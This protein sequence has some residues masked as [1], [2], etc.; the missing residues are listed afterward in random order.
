MRTS[1]IRKPKADEAENGVP[2]HENQKKGNYEK[3]SIFEK[4]VSKIFDLMGFDIKLN[5]TSETAVNEIDIL[6]TRK[7]PFGNEEEHYI[8]ECKNLNKKVGKKI[9]NEVKGVL[10][11]MKDTRKNV[12]DAIIVSKQGFSKDAIEAAKE[13]KDLVIH[14]YTY[15][16]LLAEVLDFNQYLNSLDRQYISDAKKIKYIEQDF[17]HGSRKEIIDGFKFVMKWL[18]TTGTKQ[19]LLLGDSGSGK[20]TFVKWLAYRMGK[21]YKENPEKAVLPYLIYLDNCGQIVDLSRLLSDNLKNNN[22][23]P[24]NT[25]QFMKLLSSGKILFIL[26][27]I[28]IIIKRFDIQTLLDFLRQLNLFMKGDAKIILTARKHAFKNNVEVEKIFGMPISNC[29][30]EESDNLYQKDNLDESECEIVQLKEF[31]L[32][33]IEAYF[34]KKFHG[35]GNKFY[36]TFQNRYD[37]IA[38]S[39]RPMFLEMIVNELF[40]SDQN[41]K[42]KTDRE[43]YRKLLYLLERKSRWDILYGDIG[44]LMEDLAYSLW[45]NDLQSIDYSALS[46]LIANYM[47]S[48]KIAN[49]DDLNTIDFEVR[50]TAFLV[51]DDDGNYSFAHKSLLEY[52]IARKVA[53]E[54]NRLNFDILDMQLLS[55]GTIYFLQQ[56]IDESTILRISKKILSEENSGKIFNNALFTFFLIQ[57]K[58]L[59]GLSISSKKYTEISQIEEEKFWRDVNALLPREINIRDVFLK[60]WKSVCKIGRRSL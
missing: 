39:S 40:G 19:L 45:K 13:A 22:V 1:S 49:I 26:D 58:R 33:Q 59:L 17:L 54:F 51:R 2:N 6:L 47:I 35:K 15:E 36:Q 18:E 44:H 12:R 8:C 28:D 60:E 46:L 27:A 34:E 4:E 57:R 30:F 50:S 11:S 31:L 5:W 56:M 20:T 48:N 10:L 9:V 3:G 25:D 52:L 53:R 41:G 38:I 37:F 55:E 23:I 7:K 21:A 16:K 24:P 29:F 32:P 42:S 43:I 14:L